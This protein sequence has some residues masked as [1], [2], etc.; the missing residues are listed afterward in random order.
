[1]L[2]MGSYLWNGGLTVD[3]TGVITTKELGAV[4]K[5]LGLQ[6]TDTEIQDMLNE[7]DADGSGAVDLDGTSVVT[8][9]KCLHWSFRHVIFPDA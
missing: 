8:P 7:V 9:L 4:L 6:V 1:M 5:N 3:C 2:H